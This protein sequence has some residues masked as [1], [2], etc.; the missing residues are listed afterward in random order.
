MKVCVLKCFITCF[1]SAGEEDSVHT[2][3]HSDS[4]NTD[5]KIKTQQSCSMSLYPL[6]PHQNPQSVK[7]PHHECDLNICKRLN[8]QSN[9]SWT[10]P[11]FPKTSLAFY[12][13]T[14]LSCV[15]LELSRYVAKQDLLSSEQVATQI[16]T[17]LWLWGELCCAGRGCNLSSHITF[18]SVFL[19]PH[20]S[21]CLKI[22]HRWTQALSKSTEPG[23]H[24][25]NRRIY[26][27]VYR[28]NNR[29]AELTCWY[30]AEQWN[31]L[32]L[33]SSFTVNTIT[34]SGCSTDPSHQQSAA[35]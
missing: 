1:P 27:S 35:L 32:I 12:L 11:Q 3:F 13:N 23:N 18:L 21:T 7:C 30:L 15:Q 25:M 14:S 9:T 26:A 16:S 20:P 6:H 31:R 22:D 24:S 17:V 28:I 34:A 2:F 5:W 8:V 19:A 10:K 4:Y 29:V 33:V